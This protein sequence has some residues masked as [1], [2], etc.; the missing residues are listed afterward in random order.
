MTEVNQLPF[1]ELIALLIG[2]G[3][4][5]L[6]LILVRLNRVI[7]ETQHNGGQSIKDHLVR[8]EDKVSHVQSF[9]EVTQNLTK[10]P[11]FRTNEHGEAVWVNPE[12][13]RLLDADISDILQDGWSTFIAEKNKEFV[14][15][16]W[17]KAIENNE[18][19]EARFTVNSN[20]GNSYMVRCVAY[21]ILGG[22]K[23]LKGYLGSWL[24]VKEEITDEN[25]IENSFEETE[26]SRG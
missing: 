14:V 2:V 10:V 24:D 16:E 8:I 13:L 23:R 26:D 11:V 15:N 4:V 1:N 17:N 12:Y 19:F 3:T 18:K 22:H 6:R 9:I 7:S 20:N 21:P 5:L 25:T